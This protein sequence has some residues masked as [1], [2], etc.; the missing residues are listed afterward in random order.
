MSSETKRCAA[1][2]NRPLFDVRA[3]SETGGVVMVRD[4]MCG[5]S[6]VATVPVQVRVQVVAALERAVGAVDPFVQVTHHIVY[7]IFVRAARPLARTR[8]RARELVEPWV[9]HVVVKAPHPAMLGLA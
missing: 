5:G 3:A 2:A 1:R 6:V 9:V 4:R 7:T 8:E